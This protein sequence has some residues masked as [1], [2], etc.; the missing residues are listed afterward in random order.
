M[1]RSPTVHPPPPISDGD[2]LQS[3]CKGVCRTDARTA[4]AVT[5]AGHAERQG[6]GIGA[7]RAAMNIRARTV[8]WILATVAQGWFCRPPKDRT[9]PPALASQTCGRA[10]TWCAG[11]HPRTCRWSS[12]PWPS[13]RTGVFLDTEGHHPPSSGRSS[14]KPLGQPLDQV[15]TFPPAPDH[16]RTPPPKHPP[17]MVPPPIQASQ[18][19]ITLSGTGISPPFGYQKD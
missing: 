9:P 7:I 11:T 17:P 18:Q 3:F 4:R 19:N 5:G 10:P 8:G 15:L 12:P 6:Q 14:P 1:W 13:A 16:T 2:G